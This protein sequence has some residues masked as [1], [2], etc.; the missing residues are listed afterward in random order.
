MVEKHAIDVNRRIQ[1]GAHAPEGGDQIGEPFERGVFAVQRDEHGFGANERIERQQSE[2]RRAIDE[3][4]IETIA[5]RR[6]KPAQLGFAA[7][8]RDHLDFGARE[9]AI[10]GQYREPW[11]RGLRN[12]VIENLLGSFIISGESRCSIAGRGAF[13]APARDRWSYWL[14][15]STSTSRCLRPSAARA[16]AR[17]MAVVVFPTPPF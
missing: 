4:V 9:V 12:E 8:E 7:R 16:A 17:L 5:Q 11:N 3:D 2:R 6:K 14:V 15:G 10:G 1:A 13:D